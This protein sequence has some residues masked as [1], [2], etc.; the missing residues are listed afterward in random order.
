M[1]G[2]YVIVRRDHD[3]MGVK[4]VRSYPMASAPGDYWAAVTDVPCPC[5]GCDGMIRWAENGYVPGYRVCNMC[6]RHFLAGGDSSAPTLERVGSRRS[7]I[8]TLVWN[9]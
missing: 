3:G 9:P 5:S 1:I 2:K 8:R 7:N 6:G 4:D